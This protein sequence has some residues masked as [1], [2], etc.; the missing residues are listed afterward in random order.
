MFVCSIG[1]TFCRSGRDVHDGCNGHVR[2][3]IRRREDV[4]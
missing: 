3:G 4:G 2:T 1:L